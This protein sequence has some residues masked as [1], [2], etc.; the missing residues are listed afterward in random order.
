MHQKMMTKTAR[1]LATR[2]ASEIASLRARLEEAEDTLQAIRRGEVDAVV[3]NS[4]HGE[5]IFTLEGAEKPYRLLMERMNEGAVTAQIDGTILYCNACFARM[6]RT[7]AEQVVGGSLYDFIKREEKGALKK[8]LLTT[9]PAGAKGEFTLSRLQE[10]PL[11]V[12]FSLG[13]LEIEGVQTLALVITDLSERKRLEE[14]LQRRNEELERRVAE[15]TADLSHANTLL[16][17]AQEKLREEALGLQG[18]V[19]ARTAD[20]RESVQ[21]LEQ[22][23]YTIAHDLRAPLRSIHGFTHALLEEFNP[24]FNALAKDYAGR[25][26]KASARMDNLIRDLLAYGRLSSAHL[27]VGYVDLGKALPQ[28][29]EAIRA[30]EFGQDAKIEVETALPRVRANPVVLNQVLENLLSNALK[31][32]PPGVTPQVHISSELHDGWV[33]LLIQ[34]NGIGIDSQH[35]QRVFRM[36]ERLSADEYPGTGIGLAIVQKG[37]ERMG[38]K[39]GIRSER[40]K[41]SCFWLELPKADQTSVETT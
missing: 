40:G 30:S 36:F 25:I 21:S 10:P 1:P 19:A 31:F 11:P 23:C 41:G 22:F 35:H 27:P 15:R 17:E 12:Q 37:M 32:V 18:Q 7:P 28:A 34:D 8:V 29:L 3:V 26:L 6:I 13:P 24:Q 2:V 16:Q 9:G 20:L 5:Q 39:V 4:Q 33:H 14:S 38:G